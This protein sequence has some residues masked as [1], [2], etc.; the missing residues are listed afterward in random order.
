MNRSSL[1]TVV[2]L[3]LVGVA[4]ASCASVK[5]APADTGWVTLLDGA[6]G[7]DA[8]RR[9]G[10]ANW[11][12]V[13]GVVQA[14]AKTGTASGFLVTPTPY[15]DFELRVEFWVSDDANSGIYL[16]CADPNVLT[17][18]SCYE[19]NIF[20][21]RPDPTYG[22]GAIVHLAKVDP[23]PKAGGKW[24]RLD[25]TADGGQLSVQLNG[26]RTA[27]GRDTRLARGPIGLQYAA[28]VV[29]IRSVRIRPLPRGAGATSGSTSSSGTLGGIAAI[30]EADLKRDLYAL[31][32][33]AM[34][35]REAGTIDEFRASAWVAE[36]AREAGLVSAGED[37]TFFQF[38]PLR[39]VQLASDGGV[40]VGGTRLA[41]WKDLLV[42]SPAELHAELPMVFVAD[43]AAAA[44]MDLQGRIV[45]TNLRPP[46]RAPSAANRREL[47]YTRAAIPSTAAPFLA[48]GAAAVILIGDATSDVAFDELTP[49]LM[50][51]SLTID[52]ATAPARAVAR[53][54][55]MLVRSAMGSR[56]RAADRSR[57]NLTVM[58]YSYPSANV[59]GK[60]VGTDPTLR[61]EYVVFS[62]HQDHDG[63][64]NAIEGDSI[65]NGADDNASAS[66]ALL[67]IARAFRQ[68]P[69]RRS[70]LF[71]WHG[72]EE[73][74]MQGSRWEVLHPIVPLR[75]MVAVLNADMIGRN[76]PDSMSLLGI[77]PP[78]RNSSMLVD[79]ALRANQATA[80][81][82]ID[83]T[84]DRPTH[85]EGFYFRSDH[86]PYA[87]VG[88]PAIFFTSTLHPDY[89]TPRDEPNTIDYPKLKRVSD[90]MFATG[91]MVANAAQ[92]PTV[93]PGFKLER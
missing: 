31:A 35:G 30:R 55:V 20:D 90:W 39:R 43:S 47:R 58:S 9:L 37:G 44:A 16:R 34:R 78:H 5:T 66:V 50:R 93:D 2:A 19:A 63:V 89:H 51:G 33:D 57:V 52:T 49:A 28:G 92:R 25:I 26:V 59:I 70:A 91:W 24:N 68:Q 73:R 4:A 22:T 8:W 84:W 71:I 10:D 76:S 67:A 60:V 79:V 14:D 38:W 1:M 77:Q 56:L 18:T 82:S 81:F 69:A 62:A 42:T 65:W 48:R 11:R 88:V 75:S 17:D 13:D 21:Q 86:M 54:P 87:R 85:P 15:S 12:V 3:S 6:S 83:S 27:E 74:S 23:M 40:D 53:A 72:A 45:T 80:K 61:D 41:L 46:A 64:R 7:L 29:K 36:R 32:S